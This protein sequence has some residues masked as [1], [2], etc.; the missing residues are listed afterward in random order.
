MVGK[1]KE[2]FPSS[3]SC[4]DADSIQIYSA[5]MASLLGLPERG[6]WKACGQDVAEEKRDCT[7]FKAAFKKYDPSE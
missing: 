4:F 7:K 6:D 2:L 3:S 1:S 5:T